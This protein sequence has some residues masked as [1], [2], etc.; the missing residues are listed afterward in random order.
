MTAHVLLTGALARPPENKRSK[1]GKAFTLASLKVVGDGGS[2][3]WSLLAFGDAPRSE[4]ERLGVGDK[5]AV[6]GS[7]KIE[8]YVGREGET[9]VSRTVIADHVVALRQRKQVRGPRD[10]VR[11]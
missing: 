3:F 6:Q 9:R 4:I 2:E 5:L 1:A 7:L 11:S 8:I 10:A